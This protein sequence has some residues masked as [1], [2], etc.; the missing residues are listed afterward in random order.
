MISGFRVVG[1]ANTTP[2]RYSSYSNWLLYNVDR[3]YKDMII[4]RVHI[5]L[6]LWN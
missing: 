2:S 1:I 3:M 6:L 5:T 4:Q